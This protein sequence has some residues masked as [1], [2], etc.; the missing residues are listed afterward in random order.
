MH[1]LP[2]RLMEESVQ[3]QVPEPAQ[4][5]VPVLVLTVQ[6]LK[7]SGWDL[8]GLNASTSFFTQRDGTQLQSCCQNNFDHIVMT[9]DTA[10]VSLSEAAEELIKAATLVVETSSQR[11]DL[12]SIK[13]SLD[14]KIN[15]VN[16]NLCQLKDQVTNVNASIERQTKMQSLEWAIQNLG[17]LEGHSFR[18]YIH[19]NIY[20]TTE[21]SIKN[22]AK[23]ILLSFRQGQ[24]QYINDGDT[25]KHQPSEKTK[26]EFRDNLV[27][28]IYTLTGVM[29]RLKV[30]DDGKYAIYYS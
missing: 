7:F 10:S 20:G 26:S 19:S 2:T 8:I 11:K 16:Q 17:L 25:A 6:S 9:E 23:C 24:G 15:T 3:P 5:S 1:L 29:P 18:Y 14:A 4:A 22:D 30:D 13:E 28:C 12:S 21:G 27:H